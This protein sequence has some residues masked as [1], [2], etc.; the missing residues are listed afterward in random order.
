MILAASVSREPAVD[1]TEQGIEGEGIADDDQGCN[2]GDD[3]GGNAFRL[4]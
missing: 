3:P 4:Q 2:S 1:S